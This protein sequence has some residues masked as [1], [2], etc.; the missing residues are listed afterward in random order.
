MSLWN[1]SYVFAPGHKLRVVVSSAN[2]P[3]FRPNPNTGKPL[4]LEDGSTHVAHNGVHHAPDAPSFISLPIVD[5]AQ[6][7][8]RNLLGAIDEMVADAAEEAHV[9][10][11]V[12]RAALERFAARATQF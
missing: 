12:M 9:E 5:L 2:A 10:A 3:R 1:T 4:S 7:P 11:D 6:L 8:E